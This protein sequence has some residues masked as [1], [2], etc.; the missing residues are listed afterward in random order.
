[1]RW[2]KVGEDDGYEVSGCVVG[3]GVVVGF[4]LGDDFCNDLFGK[5]RDWLWEKCYIWDRK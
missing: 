3:F 5:C 1:M 4:L 2:G